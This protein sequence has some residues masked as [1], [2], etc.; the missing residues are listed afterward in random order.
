MFEN[1]NSKQK[2]NPNYARNPVKTDQQEPDIIFE[3]HHSC[4]RAESREK[5][6]HPLHL[7]AKHPNCFLQKHITPTPVIKGEYCQP[8]KAS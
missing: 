2:A 3:R 8:M 1:T 4:G 5:L 7:N 6:R